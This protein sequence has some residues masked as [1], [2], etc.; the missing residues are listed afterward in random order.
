M[1]SHVRSHIFTINLMAV[2]VDFSCKGINKQGRAIKV[3]VS[4]EPLPNSFTFKETVFV[5]LK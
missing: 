3:E 2:T 4:S 1:F 5:N